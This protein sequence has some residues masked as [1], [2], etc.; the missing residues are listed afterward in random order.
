MKIIKYLSFVII[1]AVCFG[2]SS[3]SDEISIV[4]TWYASYSSAIKP[5]GYIFNESG[6]GIHFY[7]TAEWEF[8][9]TL[10]GRD[11]VIKHTDPDN[12]NLDITASINS[13]DDKELLMM[14]DNQRLITLYKNHKDCP[15]YNSGSSTGVTSG[16]APSSIKGKTLIMKIGSDTYYSALH[17]DTGVSVNNVTVDYV[18]N[19]PKYTYTKTSSTTARYKVSLVKMSWIPYYS[20]YHY[21]SFK[22]DYTLKFKSG[23]GLEGTFQGTE[24]NMNGE[25]KSKEGTFVLE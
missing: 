14:T 12:S 17:Y 23:S 8:S 22:F 9:W 7:D 3:D 15:D 25:V 19:P 18:D 11:L 16:L 5:A 20:S 1:T 21:S 4:G 2:C 13:V 10:S 6:N 24:T